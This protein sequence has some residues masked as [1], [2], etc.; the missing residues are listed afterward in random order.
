M[1]RKRI[2]VSGEPRRI[3]VGEEHDVRRITSEKTMGG[4]SAS[5]E[6]DRIKEYAE[7]KVD[8]M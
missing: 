2:K 4:T 7:S 5:A 1:G 3:N 6:L 8:S